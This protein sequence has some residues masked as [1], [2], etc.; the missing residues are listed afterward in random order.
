MKIYLNKTQAY[1]LASDYQ[2]LIGQKFIAPYSGIGIDWVKP[3]KLQDGTY[4]VVITIDA[5]SQKSIPEL[6]G[7]RNPTCN[8][9]DYLKH[10]GI[11]L[12]L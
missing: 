10:K 9:M 1:K 12:C 7:F 11:P 3:Q 8:L 5:F 4:T 6:F 2:W